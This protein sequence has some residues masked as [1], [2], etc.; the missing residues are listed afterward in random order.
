MYVNFVNSAL[1]S[2]QKRKAAVVKFHYLLVGSQRPR[3]GFVVKVVQ[4]IARIQVL[5]NVLGVLARPEKL[6]CAAFVVDNG[7]SVHRENRRAA[8]R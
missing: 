1:V 6:V 2:A 3:N 4:A 7:I 8:K 5:A